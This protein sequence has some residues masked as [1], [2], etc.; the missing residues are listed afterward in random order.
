MIVKQFQSYSKLEYDLID[1]NKLLVLQ[2]DHP[3]LISAPHHTIQG[4]VEM[5]N[6]INGSKFGDQ[7]TGNL[8]LLIAKELKSNIIVCAKPDHDPNKI[9]GQYVDLIRKINPQYLVEIHTHWRYNKNGKLVTEDDI[10][11]STGSQEL[12]NYSLKL[13]SLLRNQLLMSISGDFDSIHYKAKKTYSLKMCRKEE[14]I[15]LHIEFYKGLIDSEHIELRK[16]IS[17]VVADS[18]IK[19]I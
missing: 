6:N 5:Y 19:I 4:Q 2:K 7:N 14:I 15:P 17:K 11:I 9:E 12:N 16:K 8:A 10:E 13:A 3:I 18:L 1:D